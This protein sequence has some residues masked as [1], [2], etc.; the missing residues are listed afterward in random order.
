MFRSSF[1]SALWLATSVGIA[2]HCLRV[3]SQSFFSPGIPTLQF[4]REIL[5]PGCTPIRGCSRGL[6]GTSVS[7][8]VLFNECGQPVFDGGNRSRAV[9]MVLFVAQQGGQSGF[10]GELLHRRSDFADGEV[11]VIVDG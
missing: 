9:L 7:A 1:V 3:R 10:V 4:G 11:V 5:G 8:D 6:R 2:V